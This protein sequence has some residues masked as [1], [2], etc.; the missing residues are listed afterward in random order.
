MMRPEFLL[1]FISLSPRAAEARETF[2]NV[3]PT[4]L[5]IRIARRMDE[6]AYRK[7]MDFVETVSGLEMGRR[8]AKLSALANA[9]KSDLSRQYQVGF[10]PMETTTYGETMEAESV[11]QLI[12][13]E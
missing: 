7:L 11:V 12:E 5:G 8:Q 1:N 2:R 13:Q 3:F 10:E 6:G 4:L 9:L